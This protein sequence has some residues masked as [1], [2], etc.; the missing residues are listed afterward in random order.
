MQSRVDKYQE[1]RDRNKDCDRK[2]QATTSAELKLLLRLLIGR[3]PGLPVD[4]EGGTTTAE[5]AASVDIQASV[6]AAFVAERVPTVGTPFV[7]LL[8]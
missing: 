1:R 8:V 6:L 3:G 4:F 5:A 2:H 7:E